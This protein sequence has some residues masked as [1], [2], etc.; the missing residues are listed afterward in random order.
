MKFQFSI[1]TNCINPND[2]RLYLV[3]DILVTAICTK[4]ADGTSVV[5]DIDSI[6]WKGKDV[7]EYTVLCCPDKWEE[8]LAAAENNF[9][10]LNNQQ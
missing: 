6:I 9:K 3:S 4:T 10:S 5:T 7:T 2:G 1:P 8:L